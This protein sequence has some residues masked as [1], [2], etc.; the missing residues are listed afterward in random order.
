M[1]EAAKLFDQ[2]GGASNGGKQ[3][4]VNQ[5]AQAMMKLL[6][7]NQVSGAIGGGQSGGLSSAMGLA[8]KFFA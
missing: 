4:V 8:Q 5:A 3:D 1:A 2:N 6:I 7:K